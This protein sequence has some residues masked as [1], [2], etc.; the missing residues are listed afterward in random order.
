M[1][2]IRTIIRYEL[3]N[4]FSRKSYMRMVFMMPIIGFLVYSGAALINRGIA[5]EGS[6]VS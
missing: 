1:H 6:A 5:P 3:T 4:I 2:K